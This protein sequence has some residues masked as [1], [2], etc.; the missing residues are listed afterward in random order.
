[1]AGELGRGSGL[2]LDGLTDT[3]G[4]QAS[5]GDALASWDRPAG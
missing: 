3:L 1:M 2:R 5:C 4:G